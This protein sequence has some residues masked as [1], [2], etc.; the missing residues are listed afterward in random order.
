M[1]NKLHPLK[2]ALV[3]TI[4]FLPSVTW[5]ISSLLP[6]WS[7]WKYSTNFWMHF[8]MFIIVAFYASLLFFKAKAW[9]LI[10][11][12]SPKTRP[13]KGLFKLELIFGCINFLVGLLI[14]AMG[15]SRLFGENFPL[16]D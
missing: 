8:T 1:T 16:F 4:L 2:K 14:F 7:V 12:H 13:I 3:Q 15:T 9:I 5:S 10:Y 6:V 11:F